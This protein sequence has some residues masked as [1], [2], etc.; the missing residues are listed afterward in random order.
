M[1][2]RTAVYQGFLA[3]AFSQSAAFWIVELPV[4]RHIIVDWPVAFCTFCQK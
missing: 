2:I 4:D 3:P 1:S